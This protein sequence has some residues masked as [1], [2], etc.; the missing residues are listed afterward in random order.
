MIVEPLA[1][2]TP[3]SRETGAPRRRRWVVAP[4]PRAVAFVVFLTAAYFIYPGGQVNADTHLFLTVS[5]LD[6]GS[7]NID[8]FSRLTSDIAAW[9]GHYYTDKAP[10]L[11]LLAVPL[12]ALIKLA[13]LHGQSYAAAPAMDFWVRYLLG[14]ALSAAPT[15][16]ISWLLYKLLE[17]MSVSRGWCAGLALTYG[18]GTIARPFASLFF[19]HQLSA[20]LC[21][22]AFALAFRLRRE[23]LDGRIALLVGFLLGYALI[24]EYPS[25]IAVAAIGIYILTIPHRGRVL[26]CAAGVGALAPL[27]LGA[28]YNALCFGSP[29][30]IG[31]GNLAGPAT[32]RIGQAQGIFGVTY[33]H[34]DAIWGVT[35]SPYRGLFFL[36]PALLLAV[37]ACVLLARRAGWRAEAILCGV[38]AGGFLLF[39]MSYFSWNGGASMGP[40][41]LLIAIP[42]V[43]L[44][45]GELVRPERSRNW[46]RITGALS[47]Y[48]IALV[49]VCAA[50][51]PIFDE[52]LV[53]PL[54][55]W[56]LPRLAGMRVD[57]GYPNRTQGGLASA[58]LRQLPGFLG[59]KLEYNWGQTA[60]LPGLTQLYPLA[61][62][63]AIV[64]LWPTLDAHLLPRVR[65]LVHA[66]VALRLSPLV[67]RLVTPLA[68]RLVRSARPQQAQGHEPPGTSAGTSAG[69]SGSERMRADASG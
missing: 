27:A 8:P 26:A 53:S 30:H 24:T 63:T 65:P 28:L 46:R 31:Y 38:V 36:S 1:T 61:L 17:R 9:H 50:V 2:S 7:L 4:G 62:L 43:I 25:A 35:F 58:L 51:S 48:S 41:E 54:S 45:L 67:A 34:P 52:H 12:Y 15:A 14:V 66:H 33:P 20:F 23:Q 10:G 68:T 56:V 49:E 42:F 29:L 57:L 69:A 40:R 11:S 37:P 13:L 44:P 18:L 5:I 3:P 55:Q 47:I 21:F 16:A 19:S 6:R 22:G 64:L 32:L 59:A 60:D 39:T